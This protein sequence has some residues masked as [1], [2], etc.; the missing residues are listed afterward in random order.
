MKRKD[1]FLSTKTGSGRACMLQSSPI[2]YLLLDNTLT[3]T[4]TR[5]HVLV[6]LSHSHV[7]V[8]VSSSTISDTDSQPGGANPVECLNINVK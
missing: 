6:T 8:R 4:E 5:S 2:C 7:T 1:V 3:V